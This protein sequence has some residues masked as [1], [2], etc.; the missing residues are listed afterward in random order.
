MGLLNRVNVV[1]HFAVTIA[2]SAETDGCDIT[3]TA[4]DRNNKTVVGCFQFDFWISEASTGAGLT[5]DTYSGDVT[6]VTGTE[7][8]EH[9]SKK[10]FQG[11]TAANGVATMLAVDSGNPTDQ[12]FC[13]TNPDG[14][15]TVS[16]ASGTNWQGA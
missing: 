2:A 9:T 13:A 4:K 14:S 15:L 11:L 7:L 8:K 5:A 6:F 3:I 16:A 1:D 12:Y 10:L